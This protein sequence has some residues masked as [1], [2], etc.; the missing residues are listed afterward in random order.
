MKDVGADPSSGAANDIAIGIGSLVDNAD[1]LGLKWRITPATAGRNAYTGA[2]GFIGVTLDGDT[3]IST[4]VSL[5]G[6]I[7]P[8]ARV[9]VLDVPPTNKYVIGWVGATAGVALGSLGTR[10][11]TDISTAA[12]TTEIKD[13]P[14]GDLIFNTVSGRRYKVG[15]RA[16]IG[17]NAGSAG[18]TTADVRIRDGLS[19]SPT[20]SSNLLAGSSYLITATGGAAQVNVTTEAILDCPADIGVGPHTI[21]AFY[22]RVTGTANTVQVAQSVGQVRTL[23]AEDIGLAINSTF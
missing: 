8:D 22:L 2:G 13:D 21:A 19:F 18:T 23:Y 17:S 6:P 14:V 7:Q 4:A 9:M 12:N 10:K 16:R 15:Y 11:S 5:V 3:S 20:N 1:R